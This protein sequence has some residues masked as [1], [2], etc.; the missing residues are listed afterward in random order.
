MLTWRRGAAHARTLLLLGLKAGY[1]G[2]GVRVP[3]PNACARFHQPQRQ[4]DRLGKCQLRGSPL[5]LETQLHGGFQLTGL[6]SRE[7]QT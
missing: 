7:Q 3:L 1:L 2:V 4:R 6:R 5:V